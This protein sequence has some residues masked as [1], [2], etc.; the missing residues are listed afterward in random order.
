MSAG[1][2]LLTLESCGKSNCT[3]PRLWFVDLCLI[4]RRQTPTISVILLTHPTIAHLGAYAHCCKNIPLFSRIPVYATTPVISLGRTLLQDLYASTPLAASMLPASS[5]ADSILSSQ[6]DASATQSNILLTAP[7]PDEITNY[8]SMINSL[9]YSQPHQP[10]PSPFSPPLDG[11]TITAYRAGHTLGGTIWHIQHGSEVVVYAVDWNQARENVL[12]GA[13]WLEGA[14]AGGAE[15]IEQLRKPTTLICSSKGATSVAAAGGWRKRDETLLQHIRKTIADGGSVL[16]PC[17]SSAR[18]LELAYL[19]ERAWTGERSNE[20]EDPLRVAKLYLASS[21]CQTTMRY[22]RSMLEWMD[23]NIIKD[24]ETIN[25]ANSS[26]RS[27]G[28]DQQEGNKNGQPFEFRA[29]KM[30]ERKGQLNRALGVAGPRV[31]LA[32]DSSME[33]GFSRDILKS[34][35]SDK[36][37]LVILTERPSTITKKEQSGR[38]QTLFSA[39]HGLLSTPT[40]TDN[41]S[42]TM[43]CDGMSIQLN[44]FRIVALSG[45]ELA[46]YQQYLA[47][48]RQRQNTFATGQDTTLETSA[49]IVDDKSSDTSS[50]SDESDTEQQGKALNVSTALSHSKNKLGLSDAELGVNVLL[51]RKDVHD[52]DVRGKKGREKMFPFVAKRKR[53]DEFG[54]LI[55][56]EEYLRAEE[57]DEVDGA[58]AKMRTSKEDVSLGQKRRWDEGKSETAR[59]SSLGGSKRRRVDGPENDDMER[60]SK[61]QSA[62]VNMDADN[63]SEESDYEPED[64]QISGPTKAVFGTESLILQLNIASVDYSAIHDSRTLQ[65]LIPLIRPRKLILVAGAEEETLSLS[66][67]CRRLLGTSDAI[68]ASGH[69]VE[70]FTPTVGDSV[71]ASVDTNSWLVK[72]SRPLYKGLVWQSFRGLG[73][74][75][76]TGRL[77]VPTPRSEGEEGNQKRQK[78]DN[79]DGSGA[80]T[81]QPRDGDKSDDTPIL[82]ALPASISATARPTT[83]ALHVGDLRLA[84]LRKLMQSI[85]HTADFKGEG[86]LLVDGYI[87]VRKTAVGQIV[88]ESGMPPK[89]GGSHQLSSFFAVKQKIYEGLAVVAAR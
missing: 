37:N 27:R 69:A 30:I 77:E 40:T 22:A 6:N 83:Q 75:T 70:V 64:A 16:I 49:D 11:L 24:F 15:I 17:D 89:A 79:Q 54:D 13:A 63:E 35:A 12:S 1:T 42:A 71:D 72:L 60:G 84:E 39:L 57:K 45:D 33:W 50:S 86:T 10:I 68:A 67:D 21:T 65:M 73:I 61:N 38:P 3:Y 29:M 43:K 87:A 76:V 2:R 34:F 88:I 20:F 85:G 48:L 62:E 55:R 41:E 18:I 31:F 36:R 59:R 19:L 8:F 9:K 51:R 14:K 5:L 53:N 7:T 78:V 47:N 25:N 23:E 32:S 74:V 58:D 80:V 26:N 66:E 44:T 28:Q 81:A 4:Q 56:P 46:T 52:Y 82:S